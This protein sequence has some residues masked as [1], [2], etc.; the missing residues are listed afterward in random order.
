MGDLQMGCRWD[1]VVGITGEE[2]IG[3]R[4]FYLKLFILLSY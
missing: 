3:S 2:V 1:W 4:Y